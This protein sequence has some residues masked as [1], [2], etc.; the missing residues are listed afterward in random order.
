MLFTE[1]I[2]VNGF[3]DNEMDG[4]TTIMDVRNVIAWNMFSRSFMLWIIHG[5]IRQHGYSKLLFIVFYF[6]IIS[7]RYFTFIGLIFLSDCIIYLNT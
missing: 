3:T 7:L 2:A 5:Q 6:K 4:F 1:C